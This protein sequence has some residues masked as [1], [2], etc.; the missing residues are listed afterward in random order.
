MAC[1]PSV[2][3][4]TL[5]EGAGLEGGGVMHGWIGRKMRR[6]RREE[7]DIEVVNVVK[8]FTVQAGNARVDVT[9]SCSGNTIQYNTILIIQYVQCYYGIKLCDKLQYNATIIILYSAI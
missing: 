7:D 4:L 2:K 3:I 6:K 1:S 5:G 9:P 8:S